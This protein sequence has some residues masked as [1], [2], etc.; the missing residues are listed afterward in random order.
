M[1]FQKGELPYLFHVGHEDIW[2]KFLEGEGVLEYLE[3]SMLGVLQGGSLINA[4][5]YIFSYDLS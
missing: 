5:R 3:E 1:N 4:F 2:E